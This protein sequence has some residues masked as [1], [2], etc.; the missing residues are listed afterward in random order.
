MNK[1][2]YFSIIVIILLTIGVLSVIY[3]IINPQPSE[4]FTEFY[5][6]NTE[7]QAGNYP[8]NLSTAEVAK[9]SM[10]VVNNEHQQANYLVVVKLENSTIYHEEFILLNNE[11]KEIPLEFSAQSSGRQKLEMFL[12][13]LPDTSNAYRYLFLELNV[14]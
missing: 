2:H 7:G 9:V 12:Y 11:K 4:K 3:I 10:V 6:L 5:V 14:S 1:D 8:V 13:R